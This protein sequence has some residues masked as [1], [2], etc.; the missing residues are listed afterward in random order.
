M[1]PVLAGFGV[2][3]QQA[4]NGRVSAAAGS[5]LSAALVNFTVGT[6]LLLMLAAVVVTV[7]RLPG[8]LP[9]EPLLYLGGVLGVLFIATAAVIVSLTG[10]LLLGLGTVAGQ[11]VG[12]L[13]LDWFLP[14]AE[15]QITAVTVAGTALT[16]VAM[17]IAALPTRRRR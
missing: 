7:R 11:L 3:W 15:G 4:V 10:V 16:L 6:A 5:P 17:A 12:A 9:A 8:P 2:A 13:L 14:A 1:L